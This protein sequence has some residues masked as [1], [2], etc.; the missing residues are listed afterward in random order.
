MVR[1]AKQSTIEKL[2]KIG[3]TPEATIIQK[4]AHEE[5]GD[6]FQELVGI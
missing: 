3:E 5:F 1:S 2:L 4:I 6:Q